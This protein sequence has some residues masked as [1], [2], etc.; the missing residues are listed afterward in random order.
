MNQ[1]TA[2][3]PY[4]TTYD[5]M[6]IAVLLHGPLTRYVKLR[7]AHAPGMPGTFSPPPRFSDP[8]MHHGTCETHVPWCMSGSLTSGFLWNRWR[9]KRSR[10]SRCMRNPQFYV[11]GKRPIV[12]SWWKRGFLV[13]L[14][15]RTCYVYEGKFCIKMQSKRDENYVNIYL[16]AAKIILRLL[17][18]IARKIRYMAPVS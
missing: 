9:G 6:R 11:S 10:H 12:T 7:V 16:K 8:D 4:N 15:S 14:S 2:V 13:Y 18:Y 17:N 5:L 1:S 3:S